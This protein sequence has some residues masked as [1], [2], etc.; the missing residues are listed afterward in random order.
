MAL[1]ENEVRKN[2]F[3]LDAAAYDALRPR[4]PRALIECVAEHARLGPRS[5]VLEIGCGTGIATLPFAEL[6]CAIRGLELS[7][8]MAIVART[9][10]A[11]FPRV[12]IE[13]ARFE[14]WRGDGDFDLVFCAQ[15]WHWLSPEARYVKTRTLLG[16]N[17]SLAVFANWDAA[18]LEEVQPVYRRHGLDEP[19]GRAGDEWDETWWPD[20]ARGI[21]DV[22]A[23]ITA[24]NAYHDIEFHRFPWERTFDAAQY[25]A[26]LRTMSV[27]CTLVPEL[28]EPF[29][30]DIGVAI[31]D[32]GGKVTR[33]YESV[34]LLAR[35]NANTS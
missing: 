22:R 1:H 8:A 24:S 9:K 11:R 26:L 15:A 34:L 27:C 23:A 19:H 5:R 10:L 14:D 29:L 2:A 28:R 31:T 13:T 7:E 3:G 20:V 21:E 6:G 25:V 33:H 35:P 18:V 32:A 30:E 4:Y 16:E 17:G 12:V